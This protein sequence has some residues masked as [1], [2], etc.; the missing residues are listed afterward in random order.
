MALGPSIFD[1]DVAPFNV[2]L[3]AQAF[4]EGPKEFSESARRTTV[5]EP[6]DWQRAFLR[7]RHQWPNRRA[8]KHSY[9]FPPGQPFDPPPAE[10]HL[11]L[12]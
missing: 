3:L 6:D 1:S 7:S 4:L 9:E 8:A 10:Q 2:T 5:E 11:I 12:P